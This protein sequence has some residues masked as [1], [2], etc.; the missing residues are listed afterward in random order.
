MENKGDSY[1]I[2]IAKST[3]YT[4]EVCINGQTY[5][6]HWKNTNMGSEQTDGV[7]FVDIPEISDDLY[8]AIENIS[9]A[10]HDAMKA[11]K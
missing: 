4:I 2:A 3:G 7:D 8:D 1:V 9:M 11:L 10:A 5:R 6:Q